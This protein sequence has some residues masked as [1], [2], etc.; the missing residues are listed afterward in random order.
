MKICRRIRALGMMAFMLVLIPTLAACQASAQEDRGIAV[1]EKAPD[2]TLKDQNGN[3]VTLSEM[4][5][6]SNV[7]LVFHRSASW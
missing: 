6:E 1:G 5:E 7:A 3:G 2:F 4:L